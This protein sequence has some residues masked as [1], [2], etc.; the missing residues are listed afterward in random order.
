MFIPYPSKTNGMSHQQHKDACLRI[1]SARLHLKYLCEKTLNKTELKILDYETQEVAT[2][3]LTE[4]ILSINEEPLEDFILTFINRTKDPDLVQAMA[5]F[6]LLL[7]GD[8]AMSSI[9]PH[10]YHK[11]IL[12]TCSA[13]RKKEPFQNKLQE[14]KEYGVELSNLLHKSQRRQEGPTN[15]CYGGIL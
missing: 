9:L 10:R 13:M 4:E 12:D 15:H 7:L 11:H 5:Q 2:A 1:G 14:M 3:R 8:A 6:L